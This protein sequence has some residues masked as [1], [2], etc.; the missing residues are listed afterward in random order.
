MDISQIADP[1]CSP[2]WRC[3]QRAFNT[4]YWT[5]P[6]LLIKYKSSVSTLHD[7]TQGLRA[8]GNAIFNTIN[9]QSSEGLMTKRLMVALVIAIPL[10]SVIACTVLISF[11]LSGDPDR[12]VIETTPLSKTSWKEQTE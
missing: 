1:A 9:T 6:G 11:A 8:R 10:S 3:R 2:R 12:L 5:K 7:G 4:R